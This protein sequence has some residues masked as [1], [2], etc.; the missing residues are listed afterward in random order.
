MFVLLDLLAKMATVSDDKYYTYIVIVVAHF[1]QIIHHAFELVTRCVTIFLQH[2]HCKE[3]T[4]CRGKKY[5]LNLV[6]RCDFSRI[7][8]V[9]VQN[10]YIPLFSFHQVRYYLCDVIGNVNLWKW[11]KTSFS[12]KSRSYCNVIQ[13]QISPSFELVTYGVAYYASLW[14]CTVYSR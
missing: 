12:V 1:C 7:R 9:H 14:K 3:A 8:S 2:T 11:A 6:G 5:S 4:D 10:L 13:L